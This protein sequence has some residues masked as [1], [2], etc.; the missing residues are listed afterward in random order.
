MNITTI[1]LNQNFNIEGIKHISPEDA[2]TA[3]ENNEAYLEVLKLRN[4]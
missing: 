4:S 2:C 3:I 1:P